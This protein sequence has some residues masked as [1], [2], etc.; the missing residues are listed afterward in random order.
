MRKLVTF[1]VATLLG[2]ALAGC[3]AQLDSDT[4]ALLSATQLKYR[5]DTRY[6]VFF[7]DPDYW[8]VVRGDEQERALERFP[9]IAADSE[10]FQTIVEHLG[11]TGRSDFTP[12]EKL[13]IYREDKRL[14]TIAL[15][16]QGSSYSFR[17]RASE[18]QSVVAISGDIDRSGRIIVRE[19]TP[20][21]SSCPICLA[22]DTR[23]ATADGPVRVRDLKPG[24]L[25]WSLNAAN[26]RVLA[27]VLRTVREPLGRG[28]EFIRLHLADGREL[29]AS[30]GHP[31]ADGRRL[32]ELA[33][34]DYLDGSRVLAAAHVVAD[35]ATYDLLPASPTGV[36]WA[37]GVLLGSTLSV[38]RSR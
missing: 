29:L 12:A 26:Q 16:P 38:S 27:Q 18:A 5:L 31:T 4:D 13:Q 35:H 9:T 8:P 19:R 2:A 33:A 14:A 1:V 17:L 15:D 32:G 7:C 3:N 25:V 23:I 10:K 24:A 37:N 22:G 34:G 20:S 21:N 30:A 36:Y 11:L 6:A 28:N